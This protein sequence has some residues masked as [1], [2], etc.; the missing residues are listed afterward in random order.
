M[1]DVRARLD[2][3]FSVAL[4]RSRVIGRSVARSSSVLF[5]PGQP[6]DNKPSVVAVRGRE[7]LRVIAVALA[8][9]VAAALVRY[10]A[11]ANEAAAAFLL[12]SAVVAFS[13]SAG[14]WPAAVVAALAA[15]LIARITAHV[16]PLALG[17]FFVESL[18][19]TGLVLTFRASLR[20][21]GLT[22]DAANVRIGELNASER[23]GRTVDAACEQLEEVAADHAL[24]FLDRQGKIAAWGL[25]AKRLYGKG[26][27]SVVGATGAMLFADE[28]ADQVFKRLLAEAVRAGTARYA[29][30]HVRADGVDLRR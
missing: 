24:I 27:E 9:V 28:S 7:Q 5:A 8:A 4:E 13:A 14:G 25:S 30:R 3:M 20:E 10:L 16:G 12:M 26:S 11:G 22:L 15:I 6:A 2:H 23:H 21:R 19:I 18:L 17:L 1:M 29:G